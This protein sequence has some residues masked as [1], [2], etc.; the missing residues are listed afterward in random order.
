MKKII[1]LFIVVCPLLNGQRADFFKESI[2]FY[3]DS[4]HFSVEGYYWFLNNSNKAVYSNIF[5]PFPNFSNEKIDSISV[6]NISVRQTTKF[7]K[8]GNGGISFDLFIEPYDT[9]LFQI[10]YRQQ[11]KSDSAIYILRTTEGWG[12]PLD[13]AEYNLIVPKSFVIKGFSYP[14]IKSY[15][16]L[17]KKIY[18]WKME[19]FMPRK[20]M[21][22]YF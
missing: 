10:C 3:L 15:G 21:I 13:S 14:P 4:I 9:V 7:N 17:D 6:F 18:V 20:D 5:Y 2:T 19:N 16:I 11:L 8:E 12:K 22:F 1:L